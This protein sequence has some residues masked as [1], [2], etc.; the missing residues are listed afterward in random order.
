LHGKKHSFSFDLHSSMSP[1]IEFDHELDFSSESILDTLDETL[2]VVPFDI[3]S[4]ESECVN[5][6]VGRTCEFDLQ[7]EV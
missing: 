5:H 3:H 1:C 4:I 2:G 6:V 7:V